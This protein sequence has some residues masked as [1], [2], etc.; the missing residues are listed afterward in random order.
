MLLHCSQLIQTGGI[1]TYIL[2][3]CKNMSL[4]F[5][6]D[7]FVD[8][9]EMST[10]DENIIKQYCNKTYL[11]KK[12]TKFVHHFKLLKTIFNIKIFNKRYNVLYT[13]G[14]GYIDRTQRTIKKFIKYNKWVHHHHQ[15]ANSFIYNFQKCPKIFDGIN[16][17]VAC[18]NINAENIE[19]KTNRHIDVVYCFSRDL[20]KKE[21]NS[22]IEKDKKGKLH[23]GY[24]GRFVH[25]KGIDLICKL[26][27]DMKGENISFH[28]WG[29]GEEYPP[30]FFDKYP[31]VIY[32]G[33]YNTLEELIKVANSLDAFLL[34][35][36]HAEGLPIS[37][38]EVMSAGIPWISTNRGGIPDIACDPV[39]T[40][41]IDISDYNVVKKS[42][43]DL[44][45]DI[46]KGIITKEKQKELYKLNFS[47]D[48]LVNKWKS[49][50][51]SI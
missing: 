17:I 32:H 1:E 36:S 19:A 10:Y 40:R 15:D 47:S 28:L 31:N 21:I 18:S 43:L 42:I 3:F 38:L 11:F 33:L 2:E 25:E 41:I 8:K 9:F 4:Y 20:G 24:F 7:I 37:L 48:I 49:I 26:S 6:I 35:T 5:D 46:N 23:F 12:N 30:E 22:E 44:A 50:F 27:E 45:N 16:N 34:L 51:D 13:N 14:T 29:A 39:S